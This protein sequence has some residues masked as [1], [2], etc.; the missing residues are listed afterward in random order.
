M[1]LALGACGRLW[2]HGATDAA[3]VCPMSIGHDED[4]DGIDDA[5]DNCP[6]RAN[7]A[8]DDGDGDG[9]GDVCDPDP[10]SPRERIAFFDPFTSLRPEWTF[11][12]FTTTHMI[13]G[14]SLLV[15]ARSGLFV[16]TQH[17]AP[18]TDYYEYAGHVMDGRVGARQLTLAIHE[19]GSK[20][21]YTA[22]TGD[23]SATA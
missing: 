15:D 6:H 12:G 14:D 8:Q 23:Q 19:T 16:L 10:S 1:L 13:D 17:Q 5:C 20:F 18:A 11:G 22:I 3:D 4:Q 2:F 7:V 21:Y 9:V